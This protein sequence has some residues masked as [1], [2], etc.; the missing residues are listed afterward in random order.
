MRDTSQGESMGKN[1]EIDHQLII[2]LIYEVA[3]EPSQLED[4]ITHWADADIAGQFL[5]DKDGSRGALDAYFQRHLER[6]EIFLQ[7]EDQPHA[8]LADF[9][10]PYERFAAFVANDAFKVVACNSGA[11]ASFGTT[12]GISLA[13]LNVPPETVDV[14]LRTLQEVLNGSDGFERTLAAVYKGNKGTMLFHIQRISGAPEEGAAALIVSTQFFW[15]NAIGKI[16][17]NAFEMTEA[18]Q[19]ITRLLAEGHDA[20][21]ISA[22]RGTSVGTVRGQIKSIIRKMKLRSQTDVVRFVMTLASFPS[23]PEERDVATSPVLNDVGLESEVWK[24]FKSVTK[25]DGRVLTYHEMGPPSGNPVLFS[26]M[27]SCMVRW[28]RPMLRLAFQHNLRVICPIRAGYGHSDMP[29]S[30][31]NVWETFCDD[32]VFLLGHLG[33]SRLPYAVQGSD[34]PLAICLA[35]RHPE[36][37]SELIGIGGRPCLPGGAQ[38]EGIGRWQQF[39]VWTARHNPKLVQFASNAVMAMCRRIGPEAML[40]SLCKDSAADMTIL[41]AP[42]MKEVLIANIELMA[43][44]STHTGPAFASEYIAFQEDWSA[45]VADTLNIPVQIF[46]ANED[47]TIDMELLPLLQKAYPW[48]KY[49]TINDAGLALMYQKYQDLIPVMSAAAK[50]ADK[51]AE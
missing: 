30:G 10:E 7:R 8:D 1:G 3:L 41:E 36:V 43:D 28:S 47:P 18:E 35:A 15:R 14:L 37:V 31:S 9:L 23:A 40:R 11:K 50:T 22:T 2:D 4:L 49:V 34:F 38:V 42:D 26:H 32:T 29:K 48:I 20:A 5:S 45:Q 25:P 6:A 13:Q 39:F 46:I 16:L 17:G 12:V 44:K 27:G 33:I 21:S 51:S 24:P 19:R